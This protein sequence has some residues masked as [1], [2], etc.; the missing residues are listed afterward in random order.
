MNKAAVSLLL[1]LSLTACTAPDAPAGVASAVLAGPRTLK[2]GEQAATTLTL[3]DAKGN[4]LTG[5]AVTWS[6]S[7]PRAVS[8]NPAGQISAVGFGRSLGWKDVTITAVSEG[9]RATL[10]V[11]PY[12]LDVTCGTYVRSGDARVMPAL[13]ARWRGLDGRNVSVDTDMTF[14]VPAGAHPTMTTLPGFLARVSSFAM[15]IGTTHTAVAGT[16]GAT[17]TADG[18][19]YS[20]SCVMTPDRTLGLVT[21]GFVTYSNRA[22]DP[23]FRGQA[24]AGVASIT[25]HLVSASTT[26][27]T[28]L[29]P[30]QAGPFS[31]SLPFPNVPTAGSYGTRFRLRNFASANDLPADFIMVSDTEGNVVDVK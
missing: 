28:T 27:S 17:V 31:V 14:T 4:V 23:V 29:S 24:P 18:Q 3:K 8:V 20:D 10:T 26:Y 30:L 15:T 9:V 25:G 19:T 13:A 7:D 11:M 22:V 12:G 6:T 5:R 16:Y 21:E 2:I 1:A